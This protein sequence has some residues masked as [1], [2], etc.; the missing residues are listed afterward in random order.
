M[1]AVLFVGNSNVWTL[2]QVAE[3]L[4]GKAEAIDSLHFNPSR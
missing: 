2:R 3:I 4:R 1:D